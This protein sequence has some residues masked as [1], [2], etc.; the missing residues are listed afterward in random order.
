M[1]I[2]EHQYKLLKENFIPKSIGGLSTIDLIGFGAFGRV[3]RAI[4]KGKYYAL[5]QVLVSQMPKKWD[6]KNSEILIMKNLRNKY[7]VEL[8]EYWTKI[9]KGEQFLFMKLELCH[10]SLKD[11]CSIKSK[12]QNVVTFPATCII[13][14]QI[15][16]ALDYIHSGEKKVIHRD[17]KPA[18]ILVKY[19]KNRGIVKL[20]DFGLAKLQERESQTNTSY[21][22]THKYRLDFKLVLKL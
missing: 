15:L 3:F 11:L 18:N 12:V 8:F 17:L 13:F 5:K 1:A 19:V 16:F 9:Y 21:V 22:G 2:T 6:D 20:S 14:E 7:I 4:H 10:E